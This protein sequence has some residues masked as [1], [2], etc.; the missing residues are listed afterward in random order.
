[1]EIVK[2][3][4]LPAELKVTIRS[5][6]AQVAPQDQIDA[7]L[8]RAGALEE[9]AKT[10]KQADRAKQL[11]ADAAETRKGISEP[12]MVELLDR[13]KRVRTL[14]LQVALTI[15]EAT[16]KALG[17]DRLA[18]WIEKTP[19]TPEEVNRH[20]LKIGLVVQQGTITQTDL[21]SPGRR[22][23]YIALT[24]F[25]DVAPS[26][27]GQRLFDLG[28]ML[29]RKREA[30]ENIESGSAHAFVAGLILRGAK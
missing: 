10:E 17:I 8:L 29:A 23:A 9:E 1:M 5:A 21:R 6:C 12:D 4:A 13:Q 16:G 19:P 27:S 7:A 26:S 20:L 25:K 22:A 30:Q 2:P 3:L 14:C 24:A 15:D 28:I 11:R 18:P